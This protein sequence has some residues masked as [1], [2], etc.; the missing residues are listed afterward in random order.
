MKNLIIVRHAHAE[1]NLPNVEDIERPLEQRGYGEIETVAARL[2]V[3]GTVRV[4]S[5]GALR[6]RQTAK[7]LLDVMKLPEEILEIHPRLYMAYSSDIMSIIRSTSNSIEHLI[8]VGH[9][10]TLTELVQTI[11]GVGSVKKMI[12][13]SAVRIGFTAGNWQDVEP[14]KG[15]LIQHLEPK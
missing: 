7:R 9:N 14:S 8:I 3:S 1:E 2:E 4:L 6:A 13:G 11:C 10:P 12:P 5:S 15:S